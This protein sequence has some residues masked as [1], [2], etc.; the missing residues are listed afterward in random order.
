MV[1]PV[2]LD[3]MCAG[4]QGMASNLTGEVTNTV[5]ELSDMTHAAFGFFQSDMDRP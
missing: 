4:G 2:V 3:Y 5:S 1:V